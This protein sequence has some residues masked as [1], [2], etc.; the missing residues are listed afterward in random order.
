M[1]LTQS[2][3][4]G[5]DSTQKF[6]EQQHS[7]TFTIYSSSILGFSGTV[8][9]SCSVISGSG[10]AGSYSF[11]SGSISTPGSTTLTVNALS[12]TEG[13][14]TLRVT[15]T[16]GSIV[17]TV[18]FNV[19]VLKGKQYRVGMSISD[20]SGNPCNGRVI[21]ENNTYTFYGTLYPIDV[22]IYPNNVLM[23]YTLE[24]SDANL[25]VSINPP[26]V[27]SGFTKDSPASITIQVSTG[28][29]LTYSENIIYIIATDA[30]DSD[31]FTKNMLYVNK[32]YPLNPEL[33]NP[34]GPPAAPTN[35]V[36]TGKTS[37]VQLMWD[38]NT[39]ADLDHYEVWKGTSSGGETKYVDCGTNFFLDTNVV[40]GTP[41]YY[42]VKAVDRVGNISNF[43]NEASA[44]P[45]PLSSDEKDTTPGPPAT[46]TG[47]TATP[48]ELAILLTWSPNTENDMSYYK[49]YRSTSPGAETFYASSNTTYFLDYQVSLSVTYY[50]KIRA[51][52]QAGNESPLSAEVYASPLPIKTLDLNIEI[53]PW[54]SN[55]KIWESSS[56]RGK[57][58]WAAQD[59]SSDA[60]ITF[61]DGTTRTVTKNLTGTTFSNGVWYFY[62]I[63]SDT[64]LHYSQTYSDAVGEGKGL[65][66]IADVSTSVGPSSILM[67]DS[68]KPT[69]GSG[70]IQA[71]SIIGNMVQAGTITADKLNVVG[72]YLD[73]MTW[74]SNNPSTGYIKW[75]D[76][77]VVYKG[78]K[79]SIPSNYTNLT[80]VIWTYGNTSF[81]STNDAPP[82][83]GDTFLV[84]TNDNGVP[85][86]MQNLTRI[87]GG[88]IRTGSITA[89]QISA[90][91]ITS[92]KITTDQIYG[93]DIRTA[94]N[95]GQTGGP[96][97]I[98]MTSSELAGYSGG[99]T[100][101]WYAQSSDGVM[102]AGGGK[103]R[104]DNEGMKLYSGSTLIGR[105]DDLGYTVYD[106]SGNKKAEINTSGV[107]VYGNYIWLKLGTTTY[108]LINA[109][110]NQLQISG[111]GSSTKIVLNSSAG[112]E[113]APD[114]NADKNIYLPAASNGYGVASSS[115]D[116]LLKPSGSVRSCGHILPSTG[117]GGDNS[118][119]WDLG[120][121]SNKWRTLYLSGNAN[122]GGDVIVPYASTGHGIATSSFD[123]LL[124]PSSDI[125]CF[126]NVYPSNA[127]GGN[128]DNVLSLGG[129]GN[130]WSD[131]WATTTHFGDVGF[132]EKTCPICGEKFEVGDKL[133]LVVI[134]VTEDTRCVPC[135]VECKNKPS[136]P[137]PLPKPKERGKGKKEIE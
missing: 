122:V 8:T 124:K 3:E 86:L 62:W 49:I 34:I 134:D 13:K 87:D 90:G 64:S 68:Y 39:E 99:T 37:S 81:S 70:V 29:A 17:K 89:D 26:T 74:Y 85:H 59:G 113:V 9:L 95:V 79:V 88:T 102:Y 82:G 35:L 75:S 127:T 5:I 116:L 50:Y 67:F 6:V 103:V 43:S 71:N 121:S 7:V 69:I 57:F 40:I 53:K 73:S 120:T 46:P 133:E 72:I 25:T 109:A 130:R 132:A 137:L 77:Y 135:H 131:I 15:G 112:V 32:K 83:G 108:G 111:L 55:L 24:R 10:W 4:V 41:Y 58:Y 118:N 104:L 60:T 126:G 2:F 30:V 94:Q 128:W 12:S 106:T 44:T 65:V 56:T 22:S 93:K 23:T 119:A 92:D 38:A 48:R 18:D 66:A 110:T 98:R 36:A 78:S 47:L 28:T 91:A 76:G 117:M 52:D 16:S 97:G 61:A 63:S 101:T 115:G 11:L 51:V 96:A 14:Y 136:N 19:I 100:K 123:L 21:E 45:G 54:V 42:K 31:N 129:S 1:S 27:N 107:T 80:Y 114:L 33:D 20:D 125:R 84:A 105:A